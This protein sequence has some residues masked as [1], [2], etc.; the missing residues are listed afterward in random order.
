METDFL[1]SAIEAARHAGEILL[2]WRDRF[3]VSEKSRSD[4][5]TEADIASQQAIAGLLR[6]RHPG[7]ALLGEE[8]LEDPGTGN[9]YRWIIDPLDGT[10]NYVHGVPYFAVSIALEHEG[11]LVVG[12]VLDP[13]HDELFTAVRGEGARLNGQPLTVSSDRVSDL[14]EALVV[15][16]LPVGV[17]SADHPAIARFLRVLISSQHMQRTGSAAMNLAYVAAGRLD[18]FFSSSLKSWDMAAGALLVTEAGGKVT[19]MDEGLFRVETSD[20]LASNGTAVHAQLSR[21][22]QSDPPVT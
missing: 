2:S 16:S 13:T 4:L 15:A 5:V 22:L 6:E 12:V 14:C 1:A 8:G 20:L 3:T 9:G 17:E 7:H 11:D 18:A 19:A 21:L 10:G